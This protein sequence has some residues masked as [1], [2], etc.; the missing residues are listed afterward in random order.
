MMQ[1]DRLRIVTAESLAL[2]TLIAVLQSPASAWSNGGPSAS[3]SSP[4]YSTHD[5]IAQHALDWLPDT[6]K[7]FITGN[8]DMYLYGTELPDF[9]DAVGG[10]GIGDTKNHHVYYN[11]G[12]GLQDDVGAERAQ[13][14]FNAAL[15]ELRTGSYASA[16]KWAGA[17]AHYMGDLAV[18]GHVMGAST[19]WG[20]ET[21]HS[22]YED[23]MKDQTVGYSTS[24]DQSLIYDENLV[25]VSARDAA[26]KVAHDTTFDESGQG[27]TAAWMDQHYNWSDPGFRARV[28]QSLS[29]SVNAI[30]D[31]LH[32]LWADAGK[33]TNGGGNILSGDLTPFLV[34]VLIVAIVLVLVILLPVGKSKKRRRRKRR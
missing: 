20:T 4:E 34:V 22:D 13:D 17:M 7:A 27:R 16:A 25:N 3:I 8:L 30:A 31:A 10:D 2:L 33:P 26:L 21:H 32:T 11:S 15:G 6:E 28:G 24:W 5:W 18:F 29:V 12:R 23:Y 9:P 1:A 19:V 14:M